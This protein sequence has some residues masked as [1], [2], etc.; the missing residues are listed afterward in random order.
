MESVL[1]EFVAKTGADPGLARD[2]LDDQNWN[3][4]KA[5]NV[6]SFLNKTPAKAQTVAC[7]GCLKPNVKSEDRVPSH[8]QVLHDKISAET[9]SKA[10]HKPVLKKSEAIVENDP[11]KKLH[12]GISKATDNVGIVSL[13]RKEVKQDFDENVDQPSSFFVETPV[14]TFTL[15]NLDIHP[16]DFRTFL[17]KDLIETSTLVSLENAGRLN[18]WA[19]VGP[20][21]KLWPLATSGDGNCLLHAASLGMW[22]FHDRL[23]TLR[24]ALHATLTNG[25]F[26]E[27]FW[28]RWRWQQT[29]QNK[30]AEFVY[31]EIEWKKEWENILRLSSSEPRNMSRTKWILDVVQEEENEHNVYESLE[32]IH[33]LALAHVLRRPIIVVADTMLKAVTGE[34]LAPIPFGGIYLPLECSPSQCHRSPLMLTYDAAHFS[35]LVAMESSHENNELYQGIYPIYKILHYLQFSFLLILDMNFIGAK[36]SLIPTISSKIYLTEKDKLGL[37]KEYLDVNNVVIYNHPK[38]FGR[39]SSSGSN[40]GR[41]S[42]DSDDGQVNEFK[43]KT[44]KQ[45]SSVAKQFGSIGRSVSKRIKKN[46]GNFTRT[47]ARTGSFKSKNSV[48]ITQNGHNDLYETGKSGL[49]HVTDLT[50]VAAILHTNK[51]HVYQEEMIRNYLTSAK[52]RFLYEKQCKVIPHSERQQRR[53]S[54]GLGLQNGPIHCINPGCELYGTVATSYLCSACFEKQKQKENEM[55]ESQAVSPTFTKF[56][57][58]NALSDSLTTVGSSSPNMNKP[59]ISML[60]RNHGIITSAGRSKFYTR[61]DPNKSRADNTPH[62]SLSPLVEDP[63]VYLSNSVFFNDTKS[64]PSL[65]SGSSSCIVSEPDI[66]N[67]NEENSSD[68][69]VT[70][71]DISRICVTEKPALAANQPCLTEN[72]CFFGNSGT[73]FYCSKCFKQKET[74]LKT[75]K[76]TQR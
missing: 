18:W 73:N 6:Y 44:A 37:L 57:E 31:S 25:P 40:E 13:A 4:Q 16:D 17:E 27:A 8:S 61:I 74:V 12:R 49:Y 2:I 70:A 69:K 21:Q 30:Q 47:V 22:G 52:E 58:P 15:P 51:R 75:E 23:L 34:P 11:S 72:C 32:E 55:I 50:I 9:P 63:T 45:L 24:K 3:L 7:N 43:T 46:F 56:I 5:L 28:R 38:V 65:T 29:L 62:I 66:I 76:L 60:E 67:S 36:M 1:S 10:A 54:S 59:E 35:A 20:C 42:F 68:V 71:D 53:L 39:G 33:V 26:R 14:H 64:D 48:N 41:C 19:E